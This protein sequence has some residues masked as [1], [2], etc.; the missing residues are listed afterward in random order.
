MW[1]Y[2][3]WE[4]SLLLGAHGCWVLRPSSTFAKMRPLKMND[5]MLN[6]SVIRCRITLTYF[7]SHSRCLPRPMCPLPLSQWG[8][9]R[10]HHPSH[11][12]S[13]FQWWRPQISGSG[14]KAMNVNLRVKVVRS[15]G[16]TCLLS[17]HLLVRVVDHNQVCFAILTVLSALWPVL[18]NTG[19]CGV[20]NVVAGGVVTNPP[21][22][23][24][25]TRCLWEK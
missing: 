2:N 15:E 14:K 7:P 24:G 3:L 6:I 20:R 10:M 17:A 1:G 25:D 23:A 22:G 9:S 12:N 18:F 5:R 11:Q 4:R 13:C 19:G 8:R 21:S 16:F